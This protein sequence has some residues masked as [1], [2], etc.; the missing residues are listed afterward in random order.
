M[1]ALYADI[2]QVKS[3]WRVYSVPLLMIYLSKALQHNSKLQH[4]YPH[5]HFITHQSSILKYSNSSFA[6]GFPY[7]RSFYLCESV[8]DNCNSRYK[9]LFQ[10]SRSPHAEHV[11]SCVD[12]L[13][14]LLGLSRSQAALSTLFY[15]WHICIHMFAL[16]FYLAM[17]VFCLNGVTF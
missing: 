13:L 17:F 5:F 14:L 12:S 10:D 8:V 7:F 1:L 2:F 16:L 4:A 9:G 6:F 11:T 15:C 3:L